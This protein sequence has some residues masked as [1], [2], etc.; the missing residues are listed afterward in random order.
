M[1]VMKIIMNAMTDERR[2]FR[3]LGQTKF[4]RKFLHKL[5]VIE[6]NYFFCLVYVKHYF[7]IAHNHIFSKALSAFRFFLSLNKVLSLFA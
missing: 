1:N 5:N 4:Y 6:L 3:D 7:A 2:S